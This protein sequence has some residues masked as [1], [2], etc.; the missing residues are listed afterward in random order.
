MPDRR[1]GVDEQLARAARCVQTDGNGGA[2]GRLGLRR[3][4]G[5]QVN[6]TRAEACGVHR[7]S[8]RAD[9]R[10]AQRAAKRTSRCRSPRTRLRLGPAGSEPM[11]DS[12]AGAI[13]SPMPAA[14]ITLATS[15]SG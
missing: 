7:R 4:D 15:R 6:E 8:D 2:D 13:A 10:D 9:D 12:V 1:A 14:M 5:W 11:I 3:V